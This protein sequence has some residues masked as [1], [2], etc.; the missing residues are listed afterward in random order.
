MKKHTTTLLSAGL[1]TLVLHTPIFGQI[2]FD[3]ATKM[4]SD[5]SDA[6]GWIQ[7]QYGTTIMFADIN[8]DG[9]ADVCGRG[10][11]GIYCALNAGNGTFATPAQLVQTDFSDANFWNQSSG[12]YGSIRFADVNG[13]HRPDICGRG[14][15]GIYCALNIGN[16]QFASSTFWGAFVPDDLDGDEPHYGQNMMFGDINGDGK[17]DVC[18]RQNQ[19]VYCAVNTGNGYFGAQLLVAPE[20]ADSGVWFQISNT[21]TLKLVDADGDGRLDIC[22]RSSNGLVCSFNQTNGNGVSFSAA[23]PLDKFFGDG[24]MGWGHVRYG[25]TMMFGE[26]DSQHSA[27]ACG[28]GPAGIYCAASNGK[29]GFVNGALVQKDFS[30]ANGWNQTAYFGSL[31]L[32]DVNGDGRADICGRGKTG[33]FCALNK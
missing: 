5:F 10:A 19:G 16:G 17:A 29:N 6:Q 22:G 20:Y 26:L 1:L 33:V 32:A 30:D 18:A 9:K 2:A 12:Y 23:T 7:P 25:S 11:A 4:T 13:D 14:F 3:T 8:G 24:P 15:A 21:G 28:R 31:R 27:D